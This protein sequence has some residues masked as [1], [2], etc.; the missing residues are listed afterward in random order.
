MYLIEIISLG[1]TGGAIGIG[2]QKKHFIQIG[3]RLKERIMALF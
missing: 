3:R 1:V 2:W